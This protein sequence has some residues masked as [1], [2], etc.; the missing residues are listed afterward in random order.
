MT[1][2]FN[3]YA[4]CTT[5]EILKQLALLFEMLSIQEEWCTRPENLYTH[6]QDLEE[7]TEM[8]WRATVRL[9]WISPNMPRCEHSIELGDSYKNGEA[10]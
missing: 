8:W 9:K 3:E 10:N 6:K 7:L 1:T 4:H 5:A 2:E